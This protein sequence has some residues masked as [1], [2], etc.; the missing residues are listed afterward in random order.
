MKVIKIMN[1]ILWDGLEGRYS[2]IWGYEKLSDNIVA[3]HFITISSPAAFTGSCNV[4]HDPAMHVRGS[5]WLAFKQLSQL[6]S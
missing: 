2:R 4:L 5:Y 3:I 1:N 6:L